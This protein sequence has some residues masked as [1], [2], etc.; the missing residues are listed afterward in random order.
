VTVAPPPHEL[1]DTL[2]RGLAHHQQGQLNQAELLYL[3]VLQHVPN[4]FDAW[5]LLGVVELQRQNFARASEL[6]GNALRL[7]SNDASAY[8]N[9]GAALRG[10]KRP[11]DALASYDRA[12]ALKPDYAEALNNR[13]NLVRDLGRPAEALTGYDQALAL[14]P[15]YA[16]ALASRGEVLLGQGHP[17]AAIASFDRALAIRPDNA[18]TLNIRGN[19]LYAAGRY[20]EA[21]ASF[22]HALAIR[23]DSAGALN[24]RGNALI[25]LHRPD[26]AIASYDRAL[27]LKPDYIEALNNRGAALLSVKRAAEALAEFDRALAIT[28]DFAD[29]LTNRGVALRDLRHPEAALASFERALTIEPDHVDALQNR[30]Y[31]LRGL[32][33]YEA[34]AEA[35]TRLLNVQPRREYIAGELVRLRNHCCDWG[36][37]RHHIK[38]ITAN[39]NENKRIITPF[40]F[41]SVSD[42]A[43]TQCRCAKLLVN[44]KFPNVEC[45]KWNGAIYRHDKIRVAY[46][47]GEFRE[48]AVVHLAMGL[49]ETHDKSRFETT[50]ISLGQNSTGKL[51]SKLETAFT[52]FIDVQDKSDHDVAA[53]LREME[54]DIAIDLN[55]HTGGARPGIFSFRPAPIQVNFL[56]Y[57]GTT[58]A[59]FIDY[60]I[61]DRFL[62]PENQHAF[63]TEKVVYL[64][65][66]YQ[67]NDS[68]RRIGEDATT[69]REAGLP[70]S[71]FVFCSFNNNYKITPQVF[72]IW[73]RL[74][75]QIEGSVLWLLGSNPA[76]VRNLRHNAEMSGI[77]PDRLVFAPHLGVEDHLARHRLADLM[78]DTLPYNAHTTASDALWAGL[79]IVTCPGA[80]FAARVTG[81]LLHAV[82]LP[83]LIAE[84]LADYEAMALDLARNPG[85]LAAI[86]A[87]LWRNRDTCPLFATDRYRRHIESAYTTM[88]QRYQRGE[89]PASFAVDPIQ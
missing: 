21:L 51:Q 19:A 47:S 7:N 29:A 35:F 82:G 44:D 11:A 88:Y 14:K 15:D 79:P 67:P 18:E 39:I 32:K 1:A 26:E 78:L 86:K 72:D 23:P 56:G 85:K 13:A 6:I 33:D 81:S 87:K 52:H 70:E 31:I 69:R 40:T 80:S 73:L 5:H 71:G 46:L 17:E 4:Q 43:E 50:A 77:V 3:Q 65:D 37:Y 75:H 42:N 66:T 2:R 60:I 38:W 20:D 83:E 48:H 84:T 34:A 22:D 59:E 57:P 89:P 49:F 54:I 68:N 36:D 12:L 28:P 25:A 24:N 62:I 41:L 10:L 27:L 45:L 58:G 30:G 61:A 74:L 76:A 63:Y 9:L 16:E 55:G 64:P 53:L 8:S